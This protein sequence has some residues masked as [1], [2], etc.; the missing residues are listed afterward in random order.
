[1]VERHRRLKAAITAAVIV[2]LLAGCA[3]SGPGEAPD[4]GGPARSSGGQAMSTAGES[5]LTAASDQRRAGDLGQ[6]AMT[7]ERALRIEPRQ[8]ALWLELALV[9]L[10]EG[11]FAQAEQLA[12]KAGSLAPADSPLTDSIEAVIEQA[13]RR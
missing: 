6:A 7:L 11:N 1:M 3:A 12:R 10:D 13:R 2:V 5:L 8:P 4:R 9:R